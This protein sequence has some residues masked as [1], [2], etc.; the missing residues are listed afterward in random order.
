MDLDPPDDTKRVQRKV[1]FAPKPP[2]KR[3]V[4]PVV[5]TEGDEDYGKAKEL[6]RRFHESQQAGKPKVER[7]V[8]PTRVAFGQGASA[9]SMNI[10]L[11]A[12]DQDLKDVDDFQEPWNYNSY[13]P[14]SLPLR[15]PYSGNPDILDEEEFGDKSE[16]KTS[17]ESTINPAFDESTINPAKELGLLDS[18]QNEFSELRMLFLQL[19]MSLPMVKRAAVAAGEGTAAAA[20]N[21]AAASIK[22]P[23]GAGPR[24]R[25]CSLNEL[26]GG[27][28]GKMLVYKSGAVKLKL[29]DTIFD[30]SSGSDCVFAQDVVAIN[31]KEKT[32]CVLG[33][34]N[35]RA[36]VTPD[37]DLF[38]RGGMADLAI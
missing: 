3:D 35:K 37:V 30:V 20:G 11:K 8:A 16:S 15:I 31:T 4:K 24:E 2:P 12:S 13:C 17:E 38:L 32:C 7:K 1:R 23:N 33:E 27:H 29:G 21:G 36:S 28:M 5:K 26:P 34:L 19:P 6:M 14:V 22:P 18:W 25:A 10:H 9:S